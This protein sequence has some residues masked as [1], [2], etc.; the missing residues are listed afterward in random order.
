MARDARCAVL[1]IRGPS[2]QCRIV[3]WNTDD[4]SFEDGS[5]H[6]GRIY[7][8]RCDI[9]PDGQLLLYFAADFHATSPGSEA[10]YSVAWT[11]ISRLPWLTALALWPKGDCW[12]GGGRFSGNRSII[13]NHGPERA[14]PHP[15]HVP[16]RHLSVSL[17]PSVHGE[18][19]PIWSK[20]M[21]SGGW[22]LIQVGDF[23]YS[24]GRWVTKQPEI[25]MRPSTTGNHRLVWRT[26][27]IDFEHPGGPYLER[28]IV[29]HENGREEALEE[30]SWAEFDH[31]G[32]VVFVENG[33][34]RAWNPAAE[35][36][37]NSLLRRFSIEE[38]R[39]V[40]SPAW[41]REWPPP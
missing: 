40:R 1:F 15:K 16:G 17:E 3:R 39:H 33:N 35:Y 26:E 5:W 14:K 34:L 13:L 2:K 37:S 28:F 7:D 18:D 31:R 36:R 27:A 8:R 24:K 11:A 32:R 29:V 12:H 21:R 4:D 20:R 9:S 38:H 30:A 23:S 10:A 25:W 41:A 19:W 6:H 22:K